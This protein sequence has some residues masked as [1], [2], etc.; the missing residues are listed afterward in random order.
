MKLPQLS[1]RDLFWLVLVAAMGCGWWVDRTR[2][3]TDAQ[4]LKAT[5]HLISPGQPNSAWVS[6]R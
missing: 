6:T 1:L 5:I 3:K 4:H 2:L